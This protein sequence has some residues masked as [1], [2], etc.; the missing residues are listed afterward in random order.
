MENK[1]KFARL[2]YKSKISFIEK[3]NLETQDMLDILLNYRITLDN[4][5]HEDLKNFFYAIKKIGS[6]FEFERL[7]QVGGMYEEYLNTTKNITDDSHKVFS[8]IIKGIG[9]VKEELRSLRMELIKEENI[10]ISDSNY[11][12]DNEKTEENKRKKIL[13]LDDDVL[14]LNIIKDAFEMRGHSIIT[15]SKS[16]DAIKIITELDIDLIISDIVLPELD[17]FKILELL[18][19]KNMHVPVIFLTAKQV[20]QD[21]IE[22]LSKGVDDYITKPFNL[23]EVIARVERALERNDNY[24]ARINRDTFTGAYN[25]TYFEKKIKEYQ[26]NIKT[27]GIKLSVAFVDIDKF[28][29]INDNYGHLVGDFILKELISELKEHL[30]DKDLIFRFG[31]DEFIILFFNKDEEAAYSIMESFR[32]SIINKK[33]RYNELKPHINISISTGIT[34]VSEIDETS[35]IIERADKCLYRSKNSGRNSTICYSKVKNKLN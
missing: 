21:K 32:N 4:K 16:Y 10:L 24:K 3:Y 23:E 33:F 17:G 34:Y 25:K 7:S 13:I 8:N 2:L 29:E 5:N 27:D 12:I 9:I 30:E 28:K 19:R 26:N 35:M 31:G 15:T 18:K 14:T 22:A 11:Y 1:S 20:I 6:M